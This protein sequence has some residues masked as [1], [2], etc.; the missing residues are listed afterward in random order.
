VTSLIV[1]L[2]EKPVAVR[3][4]RGLLVE[5]R[6]YTIGCLVQIPGKRFL[7]DHVDQMRNTGMVHMKIPL[8]VQRVFLAPRY[9]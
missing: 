7:F 8:Y 4:S 9:W 3:F 6:A 1:S 2:G 5:W